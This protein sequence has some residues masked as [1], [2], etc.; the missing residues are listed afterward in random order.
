MA[1]R[2]KRRAAK[3]KRT[4]V[5]WDGV[6]IALPCGSK[7][8]NDKHKAVIDATVTD[9]QWNKAKRLPNTGAKACRGVFFNATSFGLR[10][11]TD[12][13]TR[14]SFRVNRKTGKPVRL[15]TL[16]R[17][18]DIAKKGGMEKAAEKRWTRLKR[19]GVLC[20]KGKKGEKRISNRC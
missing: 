12:R 9:A 5:T 13:A 6:R 17:T 8:L 2:K 14:K 10:C 4:K 1:R 3:C 18:K 15:E 7:K 16:R 19:A 20:L 11:G